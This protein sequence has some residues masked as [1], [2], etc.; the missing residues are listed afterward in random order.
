MTK[1]EIIDA[2]EEAFKIAE[3]YYNRTFLRPNKFV[4]ETDKTRAGYCNF[5]KKELGFNVI[6][7][8][9][10]SSVFIETVK[11]EVAHWIDKEVYGYQRTPSGR[12]VIHGRTWKRIM[13]NVYGLNPDRCHTFDVAN[14]KSRTRVVSRAFTYSCPCNTTFNLTS[15]RH[16]KILKGWTYTC[17]KC[18]GKI[19][20]VK[21]KTPAELQIEK[22][23]REL[24]K[25]Q[26][27]AG[28]IQTSI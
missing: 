3:R 5:S 19:F 23:Q 16:N 24:E 27:A 13:I 12:R 10:N 2:T 15:V 22:L 4:W 18:R 9:E 20:L 1:Q 25:L 6:L 17:N 28:N 26:K 21:S 8:Q 7:A 14:V 11:H